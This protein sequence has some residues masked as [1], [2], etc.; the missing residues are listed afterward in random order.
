MNR[1]DLALVFGAL[2]VARPAR[3]ESIK[4]VGILAPGPLRPIQSF[5]DRLREHGWVEGSTVRFEDRW[6][7][8]DDTRYAALA[9]ELAALPVDI[10]ATWSTPAV[11]AAKQASATIPIVMAAV[12]DPVLIGA[13]S[14]LARP[15]GNVTGFS[16]QNRELEAKRLELLREAAPNSARVA[17]LG[18]TENPYVVAALK[19]LKEIAERGGLATEV[20]AIAAHEDLAHGLARL[21][22]ARPDGVLVAA[23]PVLFPFRKTIVEF[24]AAHRLPAVYPFP[25][26]A[27]AGGLISYSTNFDDLFR[28][29][30]DYVDRILRGAVPGEL[31]VQQA[32]TFKLIVNLKAARAIGLAIPQSVLVR[33]DAVIE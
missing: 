4:T 32:A 14:N 1:R 8:G 11:L 5:K 15:G 31:P 28:Q 22:E 7:E 29:A 12:G 33:A 27:E 18:N 21:A 23:A 10:M 3:A 16:T 2:L 24:M 30:A 20:V 6:A 13:V 17:L 9:A 26:F 25:E 19:E